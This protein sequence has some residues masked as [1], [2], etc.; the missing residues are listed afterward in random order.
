MHN[1]STID[2][3]VK[4]LER[5]EGWRDEPYYCSEDFPT[6]GFGFKLGPKHAPLPEFVLPREAGEAWLRSLV[7]K[8]ND[9]LALTPGANVARRAILLSMAYQLGLN[10]CLGFHNMWRAIQAGD[11]ER[12]AREALDS[13][14]AAQTPERAARHAEVLRTGTL[15]GA[16]L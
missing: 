4:I 1:N 13:L 7:I 6:V 5:E 9:E 14:W 8:I 2:A 10:G 15:A 3:T 16:Y 12:A 11:W